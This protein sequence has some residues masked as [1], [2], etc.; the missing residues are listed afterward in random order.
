MAYRLQF[1]CRSGEATA[2]DALSRL[3]GDLL[4]SGPPIL[5][6]VAGPIMP[7]LELAAMRLATMTAENKAMA[8]WLILEVHVGIRHNAATV[9]EVDPED[10]HA[11]WGSDL[12]AEITISGD[13]P[14]WALLNRIW[15][16]LETLWSAVAWDEISRFDV[17]R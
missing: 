1:F 9:I 13:N 2:R 11:I 17:S 15:S 4:A 7:G 10:E 8:D 14:D 16:A 5:G 12:R 6:E 3:L